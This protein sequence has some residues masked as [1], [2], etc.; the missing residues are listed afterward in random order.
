LSSHS[1]SKLSHDSS[2]VCFRCSH[3]LYHAYQ[4]GHHIHLPFVNSTSCTDYN[5]N[6]IHCD[7]W[8]RS[9]GRV[10]TTKRGLAGHALQSP[11]HNTTPRSSHVAADDQTVRRRV[12]RSPHPVVYGGGFSHGCER[13]WSDGGRG[14]VLILNGRHACKIR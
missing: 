14:G 12:I 11:Q 4:L 9:M 10:C 8:T 3:D 7:L 6:L 13:K 1:L 5:F 2:A